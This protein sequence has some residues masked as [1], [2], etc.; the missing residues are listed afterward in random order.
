MRS[1]SAPIGE[2]G[3]SSAG[4][5]GKYAVLRLGPRRAM[6]LA[7]GADGPRFRD[8]DCDRFHSHHQPAAARVVR[9]DSLYLAQSAV[10]RYLGCARGAIAQRFRAVDDQA[11]TVRR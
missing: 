2:G 6:G 1:E 10:S 3:L 8:S 7:V 4:M 9:D 11:H 5:A